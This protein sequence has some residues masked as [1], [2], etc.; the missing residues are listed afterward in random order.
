MFDLDVQL[1]AHVH[2]YPV[3]WDSTSEIYRRADL[4]RPAWTATAQSL[5]HTVED[6]KMLMNRFKTIK[7]TYQENY[8]RVA[9]SKRSGVGSNDVYQ[10]PWK[11]WPHLQF[12]EK[13]CKMSS[14]KCNIMPEP[15]PTQAGLDQE[16]SQI[17]TEPEEPIPIDGYQIVHD[18][19]RRAYVW[20]VPDENESSAQIVSGNANNC[21]VI[22]DNSEM[23]TASVTPGSLNSTPRLTPSSTPNPIPRPSSAL[24]AAVVHTGSV[25]APVAMQIPSISKS[26]QPHDKLT[27]TEFYKKRGAGKKAKIDTAMDEALT[28]IKGMSKEPEIPVR[29]YD[30]ADHLAQFMADRLWRI[31]DASTRKEAE[32]LLM[33]DIMKF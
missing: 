26:S 31:D 22:E 11:L 19:S 5:G 9:S 1:V 25:S 32:N 13:T 16:N 8:H 14:S 7:E 20:I 6:V 27:T 29:S 15:I 33:T 10:P 2:T 24:N 23:E 18:P 3:L 4:K 17:N 12:L 30:A 21:S 28:L